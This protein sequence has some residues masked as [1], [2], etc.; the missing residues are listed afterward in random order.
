MD[1]DVRRY[2]ALDYGGVEN[3]IHAAREA[4]NKRF[5]EN[6]ENCPT[7][8]CTRKRTCDNCFSRKQRAT[9][10]ECGTCGEIRGIVL[11][12]VGWENNLPI[13]TFSSWCKEHDVKE[14][15]RKRSEESCEIDDSFS[16][17]SYVGVQSFKSSNGINRPIRKFRRCPVVSA[18]A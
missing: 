16:L 6:V 1:M 9:Y 8:D 4:A 15:E 7:Q 2:E 3:A 5:H 14:I 12:G 17:H 13:S 11:R 18:A 10:G